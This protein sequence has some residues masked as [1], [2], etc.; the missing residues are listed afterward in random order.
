[1]PSGG[2]EGDSPLIEEME[3]IWKGK[4]ERKMFCGFC[5]WQE[6][7]IKK[8]KTTFPGNLGIMKRVGPSAY[9]NSQ[10]PQRTVA[11]FSGRVPPNENVAPQGTL[12]AGLAVCA[13][14]Q[15]V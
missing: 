6:P 15:F 12:L 8:R 4:W 7:A 9:L 10:C 13:A 2:E 11:G 5:V 14:S 1:M 3:E